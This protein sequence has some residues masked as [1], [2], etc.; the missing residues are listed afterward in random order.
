MSGTLRRFD[1]KKL[2]TIGAA[3]AA[4]SLLLSAQAARASLI[5]QASTD[6]VTYV[7][8]ATTGSPSVNH[9]LCAFCS[10]AVE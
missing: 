6:G 7:N 8:E 9:E 1:M 2:I 4:S 3:I 10:V 5:I